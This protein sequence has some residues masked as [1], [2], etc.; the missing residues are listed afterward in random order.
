MEDEVVT[1]GSMFPIRILWKNDKKWMLNPHL[2]DVNKLF[3]LWVYENKPIDH[4]LWDPGEWKWQ[5]IS[6][7]G[8]LG[9]KIPFF[10]TR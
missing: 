3:E 10:S 9:K 5:I 8:M 7:Q 1:Q 4:L 6:A 2:N